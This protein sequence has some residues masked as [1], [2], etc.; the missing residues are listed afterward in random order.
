[1]I[2]TVA[3]VAIVGVVCLGVVAIFSIKY[4]YNASKK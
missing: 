2:S 1:M 4:L 3:A